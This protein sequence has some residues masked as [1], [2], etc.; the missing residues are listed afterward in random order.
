FQLPPGVGN[1]E[2]RDHIAFGL[3][4]LGDIAP[5][6][7]VELDDLVNYL[8]QRIVGQIETTLDLIVMFLG[9]L[10]EVV[11]EDVDGYVDT[12]MAVLFPVKLDQQTFLEIAG[13]DTGR[14]E[15][16]DLFYQPVD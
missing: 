16:L 2:I 6:L 1:K 15:L 12:L 4:D 10:V 7:G 5:R 3:I 14:I 9:E 11:G 13:G 8:F